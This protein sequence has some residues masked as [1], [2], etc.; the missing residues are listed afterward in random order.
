MSEKAPETTAVSVGDVVN[1]TI[2]HL[3][4]YGAFVRL[5]SGQKAMVH[6]SELSHNYVKKVED[7]LEVGQK[8]SAKVIKIDDKGRI[9]LSIKALQV[10]EPQPRPVNREDD[11]EK[12]LAG[13][14]KFSDEKIADLNSKSKDPRGSKR[15]S[16]G[17][18]K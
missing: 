10:R 4:A 5:E 7:I 11:F 14:M 18:K 17:G 13:F 9:D 16:T 8:V 6:I 3:A 12:K 2:E 15:R 1:G